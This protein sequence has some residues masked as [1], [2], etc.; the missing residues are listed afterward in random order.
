MQGDA[1][2][3][4]R[5]IGG[6]ARG[7]RLQAPRGRS[8]RP[9][10]DFLRE[11]LFDLVGPQVSGRQVL[12]LYAGTGAVGIEALSR[13]AARA[14]FVERDRWAVATL[15]RNLE[16]SGF[17]DRA[18]V[19]QTDVRRYLSRAGIGSERFF[20]IFLDPPYGAADVGPILSLISTTSLL[21]PD[22]VTIL[23]RSTKSAPIPAPD[24]LPRV[25]TIRHGDSTLE[26]YRWEAR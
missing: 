22:G 25:R 19:V 5:I 8:T 9:T 18:T 13:G 11:V 12:D 1:A 3:A 10:S 17:L 26:C 2:H 21:E 4:M 6:A 24:R 23:E 16:G 14:V 7:R 20:L 15:R